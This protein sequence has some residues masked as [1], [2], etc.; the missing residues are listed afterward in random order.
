M[1]IEKL[2]KVLQEKNQPAF[3]LKQIQKAVFQEDIVSF[4]EISTIAKD[5]R[6]FLEKEMK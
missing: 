2:K 3:R 4:S 6:E 1:N 5:L